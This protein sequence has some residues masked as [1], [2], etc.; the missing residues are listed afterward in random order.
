MKIISFIEAHHHQLI[1]RIL[2]Y[3]GLWSE[4]AAHAPLRVLTLFSNDRS[5]EPRL[6]FDGELL[7]HQR[8]EPLELTSNA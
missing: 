2:R 8:R 1:K 4:S 7:K 6:E 3:C 5:T